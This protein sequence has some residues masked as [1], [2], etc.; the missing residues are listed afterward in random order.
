MKTSK[1][2][3]LQATLNKDILFKSLPNWRADFRNTK[4]MKKLIL[5]LLALTACKASDVAFDNTSCAIT[6]AALVTE[7]PQRWTCYGTDTSS[8][9]GFAFEVRPNLVTCLY[10]INGSTTTNDF[11]CELVIERTECTSMSL[12]RSD[13]SLHLTNFVYDAA[14]FK[15]NFQSEIDGEI[16]ESSPELICSKVDWAD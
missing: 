13:V 7:S 15:A 6:N 9:G 5:L 16:G 4:G 12:V 1:K 8:N 11:G 14:G 3:A 10:G 2:C